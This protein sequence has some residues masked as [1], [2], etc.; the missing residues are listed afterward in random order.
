MWDRN[1]AFEGTAEPK[2]S[3]FVQ[4]FLL[5]IIP[6]VDSP[7]SNENLLPW[8]A[9]V[10]A[11]PEEG[12]LPAGAP[13]SQKRAKNGISIRVWAAHGTAVTDQIR[14]G[15]LSVVYAISVSVA[16]RYFRWN[17]DT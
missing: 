10:Q 16:P 17:G 4:N 5:S 7:V 1:L 12:E 8:E 9:A 14:A 15:K 3:K 6:A 13:C 2:P 11:V